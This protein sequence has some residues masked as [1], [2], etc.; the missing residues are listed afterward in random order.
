MTHR[1]AIKN[2]GGI[3]ILIWK[4]KNWIIK[5]ERFLIL[6]E[7]SVMKQGTQMFFLLCKELILFRINLN[8][9][10]YKNLI[11]KMFKKLI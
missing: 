5:L 7:G 1:Q 8:D 4:I 3:K 10:N 9:F 6:K 2:S 11:C